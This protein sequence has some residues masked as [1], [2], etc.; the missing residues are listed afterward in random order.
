[1]KNKYTIHLQVVGNPVWMEYYDAETEEDY[2]ETRFILPTKIIIDGEET[3]L[4]QMERSGY[5]DYVVEIDVWRHFL[6]INDMEFPLFIRVLEG[7][8]ECYDYFIGSDVPFDITKLQFMCS[9]EI[10]DFED[11]YVA[12]FI[13]YNGLCVQ[14]DD[15]SFGEN[16]PI[17]GNPFANHYEIEELDCN[18]EPV[19]IWS[20]QEGIFF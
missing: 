1:M 10:E 9:R 12:K 15:D 4:S 2:N 3:S 20:G 5:G 19:D 13:M 17:Q 14:A 16:L 7:K 6:E 8:S 11:Y 18:D